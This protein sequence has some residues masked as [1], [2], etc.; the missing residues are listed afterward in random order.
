MVSFDLQK[1]FK[2]DVVLLFV[3]A[4]I[5]FDFGVRFKKVIAK[6]DV[7]ELNAYVFS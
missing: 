1:L 3:F 4:F 5:A 6:T 7:G 2:F